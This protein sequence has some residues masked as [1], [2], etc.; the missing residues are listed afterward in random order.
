MGSLQ[1]SSQGPHLV[2]HSGNLSLF[3]PGVLPEMRKMEGGN[4]PWKRGVYD[5]MKSKVIL[6]IFIAMLLMLNQKTKQL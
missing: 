3:F 2:F 1:T 6:V 4:G 5:S